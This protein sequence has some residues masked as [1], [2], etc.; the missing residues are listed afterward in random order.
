[1]RTIPERWIL[2]EALAKKVEK[3]TLQEHEEDDDKLVLEMA[4]NFMSLVNK[5]GRKGVETLLSG[6]LR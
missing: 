5:Y 3:R 4:E 1:M 2:E 6:R